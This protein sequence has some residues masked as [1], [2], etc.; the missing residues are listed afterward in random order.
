MSKIKKDKNEL[1]LEH[2]NFKFKVDEVIPKNKINAHP[3]FEK[4]LNLA[5]SMSEISNFNKYRIGAVL[6]IKNKI[7]AR[8]YNSQKGHPLQ[9]RYNTVRTDMGENSHHPIHAEMDVLKKLKG[10][11]LKNAELFIYN[12]NNNGEQRMARPCGA[13][14]DA[15]K[16]HGIKTIHY[17]TPDGFATE[18]IDPNQK[19][20]VYKAR[21]P[22]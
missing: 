6:V 16:E 15:L 7:I 14:M 22:I 19:I 21:R 1:I 20:E 3:R 18:Y 8:G 17:S 5:R 12:I 10:I 2:D 4:F 11:D 13:C 9:K